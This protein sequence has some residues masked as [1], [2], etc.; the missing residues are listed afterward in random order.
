MH[1][2]KTMLS[3]EWI[4]LKTGEIGEGQ[5]WGKDVQMDCFYF[6]PFVQNNIVSIRGSYCLEN[7]LNRN[8]CD[9]YPV[10]L[11]LLLVCRF[12]T[13]PVRMGTCR[14]VHWLKPL[15]FFIKHVV[16]LSLTSSITT[17]VF[18]AVGRDLSCSPI[19]VMTFMWDEDC[20]RC[21]F[22]FFYG[23]FLFLSAPQ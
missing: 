23:S 15:L 22:I 17:K 20:S 4:L 19:S 16:L 12:F 13:Y 10:L 5:F 3:L 9:F 21:F 11:I 18:G 1:K 8:R 2:I 6:V 14:L 7:Q